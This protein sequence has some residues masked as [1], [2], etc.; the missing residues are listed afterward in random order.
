MTIVIVRIENE[1]SL[2]MNEFFDYNGVCYGTTGSRSDM[3][4]VPVEFND[5]YEASVNTSKLE[6]I[7]VVFVS[8]RKKKYVICGWYSNA[9]I[10]NENLTPSIFL[11]GNVVS[12]VQD[13]FLLPESKRDYIIEADF[14]NKNYIVIEDFDSRYRNITEYISKP[15]RNNFFARY[16]YVN[17]MVDTKAR[18]SQEVCMEYCNYFAEKLMNNECKGIADIKALKLYSEL[19]VS[20]NTK[21]VDGFYYL[22]MA[23]YHLGF[24]KDAIKSVEKALKLESDA[25]DI[26]ALKAEIL[27]S[28]NHFE[29]AESLFHKAYMCNLEE[30]YYALEGITFKI[31]GKM[32]IAYEIFDSISDKSILESMGIRLKAMD[33]KW[34]FSRMRGL[35]SK[36]TDSIHKIFSGK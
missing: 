22:A 10:Y 29:E 2:L 17:F 20:R 9:T 24:I 36:F 19:A 25:P 8:E 5:F 35:N 7:P 30:D 26:M 28:M 18:K 6:K 4:E 12:K 32:D 3:D 14:N 15:I 31:E 21:N 27:V 33:S 11:Q 34:S 16:P 13:V 23:N 1:T